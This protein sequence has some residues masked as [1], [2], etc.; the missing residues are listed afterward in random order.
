[1]DEQMRSNNA[2]PVLDDAADSHRL[3]AYLVEAWSQAVRVS[4]YWGCSLKILRDI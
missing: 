2:M 4:N 3:T 1:M